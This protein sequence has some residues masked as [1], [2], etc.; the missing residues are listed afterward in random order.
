MQ[1]KACERLIYLYA[2]PRYRMMTLD[3]L[4]QQ[5]HAGRTLILDRLVAN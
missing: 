2:P 1:V 4:V 5:E 3:D